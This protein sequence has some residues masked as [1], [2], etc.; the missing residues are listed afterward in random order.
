MNI[1]FDLS[2]KNVE[3]RISVLMV[4]QLN[5]II[6]LYYISCTLYKFS[7][8]DR[9][10]FVLYKASNNYFHTFHLNALCVL[11]FV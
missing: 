11:N 8:F 4:N 5:M 2:H 9:R 6:Y 7:D 10:D 3:I 1:L